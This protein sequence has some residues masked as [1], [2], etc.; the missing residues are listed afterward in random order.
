[1]NQQNIIFIYETE[2]HKIRLESL[3]DAIEAKTNSK[4]FFYSKLEDIERDLN[5]FLLPQAVLISSPRNTGACR[6][7]L[8]FIKSQEVLKSTPA[9]AILDNNDF[10]GQIE[11]LEEGIDDFTEVGGPEAI[12]IARLNTLLRQRNLLA[13][14]AELFRNRIM[15]AQAL[16]YEIKSITSTFSASLAYIEKHQ[17]AN[18]DKANIK[19]TI[20]SLRSR[21][22][23]F[24]DLKSSI[25]NFVSNTQTDL[26]LEKTSIKK[27]ISNFSAIKYTEN[28]NSET[29]ILACSNLLKISLEQCLRHTIDHCGASTLFF[30]QILSNQAYSTLEKPY[31]T[32]IF[33]F[34]FYNSGLAKRLLYPLQGEIK[35]RL[36]PNDL[37][38]VFAKQLIEFIGGFIWISEDAKNQ[39]TSL[40]IDLPEAT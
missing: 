16:K 32:N 39:K 23:S 6:T 31:I 26:K 3:K 29:M 17:K 30:S 34:D 38:M 13:K 27:I 20:N 14:S 35:S 22:E 36:E 18:M 21:L 40:Y 7:V 15:I 11:L 10:A 12:L 19:P 28:D 24:S 4:C 25:G 37:S 5:S 33:E 9:L 8:E 1:M 2:N